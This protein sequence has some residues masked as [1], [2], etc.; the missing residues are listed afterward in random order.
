MTF[1]RYLSVGNK[2]LLILLIVLILRIF[3][4]VHPDKD[5]ALYNDHF[6]QGTEVCINYNIDDKAFIDAGNFRNFFACK[7]GPLKVITCFVYNT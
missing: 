6:P 2:N 3:R 1:D 4:Y 7:Y 5:P